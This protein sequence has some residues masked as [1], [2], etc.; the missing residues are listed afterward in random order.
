MTNQ[1]IKASE[2]R[3]GMI[4]SIYDGERI[5]VTKKVDKWG[6]VQVSDGFDWRGLGKDEAVEVLGYFNP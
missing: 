4:L 6:A 2:I 3:P 1:Q 5:D